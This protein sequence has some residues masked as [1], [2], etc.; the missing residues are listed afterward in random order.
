VPVFYP[1]GPLKG[2]RLF[3]PLAP[4]V[5]YLYVSVYYTVV[6][7]DLPYAIQ[8]EDIACILPAFFYPETEAVAFVS[9][10]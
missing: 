2:Q 10:P 6:P 5:Q 9:L 4:G 3:C 1:P 7:G 8:S